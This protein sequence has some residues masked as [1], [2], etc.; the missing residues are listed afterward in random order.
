VNYKVLTMADLDLLSHTYCLRMTVYSL[1]A[2][3]EE[4]LMHYT[5][6]YKLSV[7]GRVRR[8]T[9]TSLRFSLVPTAQMLSKM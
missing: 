1:L 7:R 2:V 3:I 6:P 5:V 9:E 8:L 4:V